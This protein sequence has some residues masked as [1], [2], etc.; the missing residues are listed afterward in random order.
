MGKG[1]YSTIK[2]KERGELVGAPGVH[3]SGRWWDRK[4]N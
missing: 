2:V 4:E 3:V 1:S